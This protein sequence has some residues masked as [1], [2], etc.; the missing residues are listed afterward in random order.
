MVLYRKQK[1][2]LCV[3]KT[4]SN[5]R[6]RRHFALVDTRLIDACLAGRQLEMTTCCDLTQFIRMHV[7]TTHNLSV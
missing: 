4:N 5:L 7:Y 6:W 2:N 3:R 1:I